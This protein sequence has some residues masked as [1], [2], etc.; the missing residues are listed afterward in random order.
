MSG[1][2]STPH[3]ILTLPLLLSMA[4][5]CPRIEAQVDIQ[6]EYDTFLQEKTQEYEGFRK[7]IDSEYETF[8]R[9]A[10]KAYETFAP[11]SLPVRERQRAKAVPSTTRR[12]PAHQ[13]TTPIGIQRPQRTDDG[14]K[15]NNRPSV[16]PPDH[17]DCSSLSFYGSMVEVNTNV[18]RNLT[19]TGIQEPHVANV[20]RVL[21]NSPHNTFIGDCQAAKEAHH[22]SDWTY[23][24]FTQKIGEALYG[25][26]NPDMVAFL[27]MFIL[28]KSNYKARISRVDNHLKVLVPSTSPIYDMP[29]IEL[30]GR[31][32]YV[33]NADPNGSGIVYTYT[34]DYSDT[35]EIVDIKLDK[36]PEFAPTVVPRS[37]TFDADSTELTIDAAVNQNLIDFYRDYPHCDLELHFHTPMSPELRE[38]L[39]PALQAA[40]EGK[41]QEEAGNLLLDFVQN[42]FAYKTDSE[43]FGYEKPNFLEETFYYPYCDCEDRAMLYAR[44][45]TDLLGLETVLLDY[46]GHTATGVRFP[47]SIKGDRVELADGPDYLVCDPTHMGATIGMCMD[48]Y[49]YVGPEV[50]F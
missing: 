36:A 16:V 28:L 32:Y 2:A 44:L 15:N 29:Y 6:K 35:G 39:Y 5:V 40:I 19:L 38:S 30:G 43:Q 8:L 31:H 20:W 22:M 12:E 10:W 18:A 42:A 4:F 3:V 34:R 11:L 14:E 47:S 17:P 27:Q 21:C 49:R 37:L 24:K 23:V 33:V 13:P 25:T 9:Q 50:I 45:V 26:D 46:P 41:T 7:K 1:T 48:E